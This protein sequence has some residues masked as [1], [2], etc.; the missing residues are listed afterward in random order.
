MKKVIIFILISA[1]LVSCLMIGA[2][3]MNN[4]DS[5]KIDTEVMNKFKEKESDT[6][7]MLLYNG[8]FMYAFAE[9]QTIEEIVSGNCVLSQNIMVM[10]DSVIKYKVERNERIVTLRQTTD[11]SKLY[12]YAVKP[13]RIL[14][15]I[16]PKLEV[17]N[18][19]CL[20]GEP[21]HDGVYIYYST[22]KGD[23]I[24]Y[25]EYLIAEKEYL[26]PLNDFYEFASIVQEERNLN[27]DR[28]GGGRSIDE[29]YDLGKYEIKTGLSLWIT[30]PI[31]ILIIIG[32]CFTLI[33]RLKHKKTSV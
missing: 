9:K 23:Y 26:F 18:V 15:N 21:S 17:K 2:Y 25:K 8:M 22:D 13:S 33:K 19:Y 28:D 16:S 27:K 7:I 1:M 3:A 11:W 10:T 20:D 29:L 24:Y 12:K 31:A 4:N 30:L 32:T 14:S 5:V 6:V